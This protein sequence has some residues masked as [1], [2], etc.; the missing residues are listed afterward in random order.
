MESWGLQLPEVFVPSGGPAAHACHMTDIL[1]GRGSEVRASDISRAIENLDVYFFT[2]SS[3]TP[4]FLTHTVGHKT[5][6]L[7]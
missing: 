4:N 6:L 1:W 3:L 5:G 7:H 2:R